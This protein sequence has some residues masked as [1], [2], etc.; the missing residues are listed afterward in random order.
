[1]GG[2]PFNSMRQYFS[3]LILMHHNVKNGLSKRH[4][5]RYWT[6]FSREKS[7]TAGVSNSWASGD[8]F[9]YMSNGAEGHMSGG[10]IAY[11]SNRA[12]GRM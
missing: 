7:Y 10:L 3:P 12:G 11:V 9:A 4:N 8:Q 1:M 2:Q 5:V 6:T